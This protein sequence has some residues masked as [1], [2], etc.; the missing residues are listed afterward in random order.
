M[1]KFCLSFVF[2]MILGIMGIGELNAQPLSV[3]SKTQIAALSDAQLKQ[4]VIKEWNGILTFIMRGVKYDDRVV[5]TFASN[6]KE[7]ALNWAN[8]SNFPTVEY[9]TADDLVR[10]YKF[11]YIGRN[12]CKTAVLEIH[13]R[14]T[15]NTA[16]GAMS[17]IMDATFSIMSKQF[18]ETPPEYVDA[19]N[20][21]NSMEP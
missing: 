5:N 2:L 18:T 12:S 13:K 20:L 3:M 6:F 9:I 19:I 15:P 14:T 17:E 10:F 1:K 11:W 4:R 8:G 16:D 21:I 7:G